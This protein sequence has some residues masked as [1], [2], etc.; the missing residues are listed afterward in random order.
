MT[1]SGAPR[2]LAVCQVD[3]PEGPERALRVLLDGLRS[4]GWELT[5]ASPGDAHAG[6]LPI[7]GS[8]PWEPLELGGLAHGAGARAVGSWPRALRL[9][10]AHDIVYLNGTV[11]GRLLPALHSRAT[12]LHVHDMVRRVPRHWLRADLVLADSSACGERLDPLDVHVVGAPVALDPLRSGEDVETVGAAEY[13]DAIEPLL[14]GAIEGH[15]RL[16]DLL[17]GRPR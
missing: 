17:P 2:L 4:R 14:I 8:D 1:A 16:R 7:A 3:R 5:V 11:A 15:R 9:A 13:V 6:G 10:R 12:V